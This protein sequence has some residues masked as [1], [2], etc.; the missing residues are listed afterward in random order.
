MAIFKGWPTSVPCDAFVESIVISANQFSECLAAG[1]KA[2]SPQK[3]SKYS[4]QRPLDLQNTNG[5]WLLL[6][7][8]Q[9]YSVVF[10]IP[11]Q[12]K[13]L[14]RWMFSERD[15]RQR[16]SVGNAS[17]SCLSALCSCCIQKREN[18]RPHD[19]IDLHCRSCPTSRVFASALI[20][21]F[22]VLAYPGNR[23]CSCV[24]IHVE[25]L[26]FWDICLSAD[27]GPSEFWRWLSSAL[28]CNY[29]GLWF[30]YFD[31]GAFEFFNR[32]FSV[33]LEKL[34]I[35]VIGWWILEPSIGSDISWRMG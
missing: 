29:G 26:G 13:W 6:V 22:V 23:Q 35:E 30:D 9:N 11:P 31:D 3:M 19:Y 17:E 2:T 18:L 16:F 12:G 1:W 33:D 20:F 32:R 5:I 8:H 15:F 21:P 34:E 25:S 4:P 28:A 27:F 14:F 24:Q 10:Y 7:V